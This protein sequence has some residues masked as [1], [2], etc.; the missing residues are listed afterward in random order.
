MAADRR[1]RL[2]DRACRR[3]PGRRPAPPSRSR[4][5]ACGSGPRRRLQRGRERQPAVAG[6]RVGHARGRGHR[7]QA[8]QVLGHGDAGA[9]EVGQRPRAA[10]RRSDPGEGARA[11][12]RGVVEVGDGQHDRA[13]HDPAGERR[14]PAP[15]ARSRAGTCTAASD[16]LLGG[17]G[18]GVEAGDRVG[19]RAGS[20]GRTASAR[21]AGLRPHAAAAR[22]AV[23]RE[24][25]Q[26]RRGRSDGAKTSIATVS[27]SATA[28]IQ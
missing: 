27:S 4:R 23:V 28:R 26:P 19:G 7:G 14:R 16:G 2:V 8:A 15:R 17:V 22:A 3:W 10:R 6:E 25:H 12:G 24:R 11:L 20:R 21:L 1:H 9:D 18:G 13:Q 5:S